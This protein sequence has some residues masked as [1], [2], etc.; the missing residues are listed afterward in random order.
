VRYE[1]RKG[2][3]ARFVGRV[4]REVLGSRSRVVVSK[5]YR[6][7]TS[8]KLQQT[9]AYRRPVEKYKGYWFFMVRK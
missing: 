6:R 9:T 2:G 4:R 3:V 5:T 8:K 1:E 7:H